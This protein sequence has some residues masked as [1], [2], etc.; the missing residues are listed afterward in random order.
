MSTTA[1]SA[2][3]CLFTHKKNYVTFLGSLTYVDEA[4]NVINKYNFYFIWLDL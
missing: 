1:F 4:G 2:T 3:A